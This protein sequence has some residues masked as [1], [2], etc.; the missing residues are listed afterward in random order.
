MFALG[1]KG[2]DAAGKRE[3]GVVAAKPNVF[4]WQVAS[5]TLAHN[6]ITGLGSLT[7]REFNP[8]ELWLGVGEVC[9]GTACFFMRHTI[10]LWC[11]YDTRD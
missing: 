1:T 7:R 2:D 5:A 11:R 10:Y 9:R 3:E 4:T 8:Q 6:D